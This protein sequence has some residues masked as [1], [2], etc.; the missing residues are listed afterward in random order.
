M[1]LDTLEDA[2]TR[3]ADYIWLLK[4]IKYL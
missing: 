1:Q 3:L 4:V 2:F